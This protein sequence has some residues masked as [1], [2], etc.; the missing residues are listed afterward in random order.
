MNKQAKSVVRACR[1]IVKQVRKD[2]YFSATI[3]ANFTIE[4]EKFDS[5]K[6]Y[7]LIIVRDRHVARDNCYL[8]SNRGR[9]RVDWLNVQTPFFK[10]D[11]WK[12]VNDVLTDMIEYEAKEACAAAQKEIT[13][14]K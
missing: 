4:L 13:T 6:G 5:K 1:R 11:L 7:Y 10:S 9:F 12:M 14:G 2:D 8:L 3:R